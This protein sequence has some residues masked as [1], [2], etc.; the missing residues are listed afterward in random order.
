LQINK[1]ITKEGL[2]KCH[3]SKYVYKVIYF[4][5]TFET[6]LRLNAIYWKTLRT[7]VPTQYFVFL[8][9]FVLFIYH[10]PVFSSPF[11][12]ILAAYVIFC[13]Y[14]ILLIY[15]FL[16]YQ[17]YWSSLFSCCLFVHLLNFRMI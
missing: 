8:Y 2:L 5:E 14:V 7:F 3:L 6:N 17:F 10:F 13:R 11:L 15:W 16:T 4:R 9:L 12:S 1:Q